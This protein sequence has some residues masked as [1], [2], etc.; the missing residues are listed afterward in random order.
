MKL[1]QIRIR[2]IKSNLFII[3]QKWSLIT[4]KNIT[5]I[6]KYCINIWHIMI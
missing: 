3:S 2:H 6:F 1:F 5:K 4:Q